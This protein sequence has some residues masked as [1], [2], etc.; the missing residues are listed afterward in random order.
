MSLHPK[1]TGSRERTHLNNLFVR[2]T[3]Q[4]NMLFIFIR[5]E[6]YAIWDLPI[7]E[8]LQALPCF[9]VPKFH[10]AVIS[11]GKESSAIIVETEILN[12]LYVS[13]ECSQT[14]LVSVDVPELI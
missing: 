8:P 14:I 11:T 12:S 3:S 4:E 13:M 2:H 6:L 5:V 9:C 1:H 10:L 7:T